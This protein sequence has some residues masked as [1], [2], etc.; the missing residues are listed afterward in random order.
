M[1]HFIVALLAA[2]GLV[3]VTDSS[4]ADVF[5][6]APFVRLHVRTSPIVVA[7]PGVV[8]SQPVPA[9]SAEPL[10]QPTLVPVLLTPMTVEQFAQ[11]FQPKPGRYEVLLIRKR[12]VF[13]YTQGYTSA[14]IP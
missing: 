4:R 8:V 10:H 7:P 12:S 5:I 9:V 13:T 14:T 2:A 1:R 6:R 3:A 11:A